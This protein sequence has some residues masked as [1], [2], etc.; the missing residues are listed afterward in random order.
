MC[1]GLTSGKFSKLTYT[2]IS[3]V[4]QQ[5]KSTSDPFRF[6]F[7]F[8]FLPSGLKLVRPS[9]IYS[10]IKSHRLSKCCITKV[11]RASSSYNH[12]LSINL[13][14][15]DP[16]TEQMPDFSLVIKQSTAL[17]TNRHSFGIKE[18]KAPLQQQCFLCLF[19]MPPAIETK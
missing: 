5:N 3:G 12:T 1:G 2:V 6:F 14:H 13:L 4:Y 11:H 16:L 18:V 8:Y 17:K 9:E 15:R 10:V 7:Y 19:H